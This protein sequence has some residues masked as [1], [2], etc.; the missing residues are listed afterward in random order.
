MPSHPELVAAFGGGLRDGALPPG[1]T[2][3]DPA[4]APRRFAVH[5]N[6]VVQGLTGA[7]AARFPVVRRLVGEDFFRLLARAFMVL[8]PPAS[9]VLLDW[10]EEFP[11]FL[12]TFPPARG[13]PYLPDVARIELA[14]GRAFHAADRAPL[15]PEAL[16]EAARDP[17]AARLRLHPSVQV[18]ASPWAVVSI[19]RV[20]QPGAE[21]GP[22]RADRPETALILRDR[23]F[24]VPVQAIGR[25]D[26]AFLEHLTED[27]PLLTCAAAAAFAEPGHDPGPLLARLAQAGA[28][29]APDPED[30]P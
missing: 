24:E 3:R 2:A 7:L 22:L 1:V 12:G 21:P 4:E 14:R 18:I 5:R 13:L 30:Q 20:N 26:A 29:I 15:P 9:P 16:A 23:A 19:W 8:H 28:L 6:N 27:T 17:G 25:G 10:G 11:G